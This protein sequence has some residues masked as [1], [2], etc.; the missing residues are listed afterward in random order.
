MMEKTVIRI[1]C[2]G[3]SLTEGHGSSNPSLKSYPVVMQELL[4]EGFVVRNFGVGA[5]TG[6]KCGLEND[7]EKRGYVLEQ[8]YQ[9]SLNFNPHIVF[10]MFGTN[11]A[12]EINRPYLADHFENDMRDLALSYMDLPEKATVFLMSAPFVSHENWTICEE[13]NV[14]DI[15][16][17]IQN[18]WKTMDVQPVDVHRFTEKHFEFYTEDGVHFNDYGYSRLA[19]FLTEKVRNYLNLK[20]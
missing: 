19:A 7:G 8:F 17:R 5:R 13:C 2:V 10:L 14:K 11:D 4:G 18:L 3:D 16:P 1:A 20:K 12:K 15:L 6:L 9:D